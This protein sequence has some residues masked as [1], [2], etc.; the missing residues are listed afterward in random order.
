MNAKVLMDHVIDAGVFTELDYEYSKASIAKAYDNMGGGCTAV[1]KCTDE[2]RMLVGRN[3]DLNISHN[4]AYVVRTKVP[5]CYETVGLS[6]TFKENAPTYEYVKENGIPEEFRK[7]IPFLSCDVM[8]EKGLYVE[9]NMRSGELD[10]EGNP[11]YSCT[12]TNPD[13]D[14]RVHAILLTRYIGE[15]CATAAEAVEYARSLDIY[16]AVGGFDAW[17][18]CFMIADATG[19]FGLLEIARNRVIWHDRQPAQANFYITPE[20]AEGELMKA[21]LDRYRVVTEGVDEVDS[22]EKMYELMDK[23]SYHQIYS[24]DRCGFDYRSEFIGIEPHWTIDYVMADENR[25][26]IDAYAKELS[27]TL[28][29]LPRSLKQDRNTLWESVFTEVADCSEKSLTVRFF[30]DENRKMT[31]EV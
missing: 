29:K 31:L 25:E 17:N 6:Y 11:K 21:G 14:E 19:D 10:S 2:G 28:G 27:E 4:P 3:M 24:Y 8:N 15:H 9:I 16:T 22:P 23:V 7:T 1:A 13:S 5:G 30:E 26:E 20:F 12:G 18:F